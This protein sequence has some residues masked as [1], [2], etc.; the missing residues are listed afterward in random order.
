MRE[1]KRK[2]DKN[3][4]E[5]EKRNVTM[6][7]NVISYLGT[8]SRMFGLFSSRYH[9]FQ[10]LI[11]ILFPFTSSSSLKQKDSNKEKQKE[12]ERK[13]KDSLPLW[14]HCVPMWH[15]L[16]FILLSWYNHRLLFKKGREKGE[17]ERESKGKEREREKKEKRGNGE[18]SNHG[19]RKKEKLNIGWKDYLIFFWFFPSFWK[20]KVLRNKLYSILRSFLFLIPWE[21]RR[22]FFNHE[23][24]IFPFS[25]FPFTLFHSLSHLSERKKNNSIQFLLKSFS[26]ETVICIKFVLELSDKCSKLTFPEFR[27]LKIILSNVYGLLI[28]INWSFFQTINSTDTLELEKNL[29][30]RTVHAIEF[31]LMNRKVFTFQN[32]RNGMKPQSFLFQCVLI[33]QVSQ[34]RSRNLEKIN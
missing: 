29:W 23:N 15:H 17:R 13:K 30:T 16:L 5:R 28:W 19:K 33:N 8:V 2:I 9:L 32:K 1:R 20:K 12:R 34:K 31:V 25:S 26:T 22:H 27:H 14:K 18:E 6:I 4:K 7:Q 21:I 24:H 11:F 3:K 10:S